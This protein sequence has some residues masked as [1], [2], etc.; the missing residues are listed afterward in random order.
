[1][2]EKITKIAGIFNSHDASFCVLENGIPEIHAEWER[3]LR[4]KE[5]KGDSFA[6]MKTIYDV[7]D[8]DMFVTSAPTYNVMGAPWDEFRRYHQRTNKPLYSEIGHHQSHAANAFFSSNIDKSLIVTI[9]G[10]GLEDDED[11]QPVCTTFWYGDG[12]KIYPLEILK[13]IGAW[14]PFNEPDVIKR[15]KSAETNIGGLWTRYTGEVFGLHT[16]YP[17]GAQMGTVMA[18]AAYGKKDRYIKEMLD[19]IYDFKDKVVNNK[20][21]YN[22]KD[23]FDI[24]ASLQYWTEIQFQKIINRGIELYEKE[25]GIKPEN[26]CLAGGCILNSVCTGKLWDWYSFKDI[27]VTPCPGDSGI[28]IGAAQYYWHQILD[29][30]RIKWVD[31][32][33]PYLGQKYS[34]ELIMDTLEN[35]DKLKK[36]LEEVGCTISY[37]KVTDDDVLDLLESQHIISVF[38]EGSESGR[39]AL[40]NRSILADPRSIEMKDMINEKVK[41]RQWFRPFAPSILR[42]EVKNWFEKDVSSPYMEYVINVK[43]EVRDKVQAIVHD[44]G[45][46]RLQTVTENDNKW[47]HGFISKWFKRSGVPILLNTSFNDREP[48]VETPFD[49]VSC[50]VGTNIDAVY[51][52]DAGILVTKNENGDK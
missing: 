52:R 11:P 46:A 47:Y 20:D 34:N 41:H 2:S 18:M 8:I 1:M 6:F 3:Y 36:R 14:P 17:H 27:Y 38:G 49:A 29:N 22:E 42:E 21:S 23:L 10:G 50:F 37:K 40:G 33:T 51:F 13:R 45:T 25:H 7:D 43:E 31:N 9:D 32:F 4:L 5:P 16:G 30:P 48:I 24:A 28:T 39:R 15:N 35:D 26:L 19:G 12:N 44:N